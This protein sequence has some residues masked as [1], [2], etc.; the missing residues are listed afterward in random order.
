MNLTLPSPFRRN[1]AKNGFAGRSLLRR[2][3]LSR[4]EAAAYFAD[5]SLDSFLV[6][7]KKISKSL[8]RLANSF[9]RNSLYSRS[10]FYL[11]LAFQDFPLA[12]DYLVI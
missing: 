3:G 10:A 5:L 7:S 6:S 11:A 4:H 2:G 9:W 12:Q 1:F 8:F